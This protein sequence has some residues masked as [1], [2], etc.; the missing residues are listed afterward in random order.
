MREQP[1]LLLITLQLVNIDLDS[2][3]RKNLSVYVAHTRSNHE[4]IF[5]MIAEDSMAIEICQ[6]RK[7]W[8]WFPFIFFLFSFYLYFLFQFI[9]L[10]YF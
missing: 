4:D 10:F 5:F 6:N 1:E 3:L 9:F 7:K 2:S 8:T